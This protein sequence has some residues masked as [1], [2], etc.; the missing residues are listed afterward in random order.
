MP[1]VAIVLAIIFFIFCLLGLLFLLMKETRTVGSVQV[2]VSGSGRQHSTIIPVH[3][4]G[5]VVDVVQRVNWARS[6]SVWAESD[7]VS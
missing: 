4:Y 7:H 1:A 5:Q 3:S 2:T 6:M